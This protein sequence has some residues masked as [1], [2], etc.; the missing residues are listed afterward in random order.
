[1]RRRASCWDHQTVFDGW[2]W[3][4]A[5]F[6]IRNFPTKCL[7]RCTLHVTSKSFVAH[8]DGDRLLLCPPACAVSAASCL[9]LCLWPFIVTQVPGLY[10]TSRFLTL[11]LIVPPMPHTPSTA[12]QTSK[13]LLEVKRVSDEWFDYT[14]HGTASLVCSH[15]E[16]F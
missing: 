16:K 3:Q 10:C 14:V 1:M 13:I 12:E 4:L 9:P 15:V 6:Q 5:G 7:C 2:S 11:G 8:C